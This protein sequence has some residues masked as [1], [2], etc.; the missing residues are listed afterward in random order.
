[1]QLGAKKWWPINEIDISIYCRTQKRFLA[2]WNLEPMQIL[3]AVFED[4][5][6]LFGKKSLDFLRVRVNKLLL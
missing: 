6:A 3:L 1:M 4:Y 5:F 2:T